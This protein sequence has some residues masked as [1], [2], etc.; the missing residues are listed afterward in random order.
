ML[1]LTRKR[2]S[3]CFVG[4]TS[5][6]KYLAL[7]LFLITPLFSF[8]QAQCQV[9]FTWDGSGYGNE[10]VMTRTQTSANT[11]L[12][13]CSG[14]VLV[15][16]QLLN[17]DN[18]F[19]SNVDG[20]DASGTAGT[21]QPGY[22]HWLDNNNILY[23]S[24]PMVA[25]EDASLKFTF[26]KP[27][28]LV[29]FV[30]SDIDWRNQAISARWRDKVIVTA[31]DMHGN[32]VPLT[33]EHVSP[34]SS[35]IGISGQTALAAYSPGDD[36]GLD[37]TD[38]ESQVRW[39][40][41]SP[42]TTLIMKHQTGVGE[43]GQEVV[44][45][46]NFTVEACETAE[47][48]EDEYTSDCGTA[49]LVV[50]RISRDLMNVNSLT[51]VFSDPSSI[52]YIIFDAV[53]KGGNQPTY[54][55]L[56]DQNGNCFILN[57]E[58]LV[59]GTTTCVPGSASGNHR[60]Q[61]EF[62]ANTSQLSLS[63]PSGKSLEGGTF[64]VIRTDNSVL[65]ASTISF[66]AGAYLVNRCIVETLDIPVV[67]G[68]RD[69]I[70]HVPLYEISNDGR[71]VIV[72]ATVGGQTASE[73]V[74]P[75]SSYD[76]TVYVV[77]LVL[78]DADGSDGTI[79]IEVESPSSNGQSVLFG[80]VSFDAECPIQPVSAELCFATSD[81]NDILYTVD[82]ATGNGGAIG[83]LGALDIESLAYGAD[84]ADLYATNAGVFG[85][86][87]KQT[88][89]FTAIATVGSG[90][91]S[92]GVLSMTDIDG[93]AYHPS[94]GNMIASQR[95]S[96]QLDLIF[97]INPNTGLLVPNSFGSNVDY[98]V[99]SGTNV[100]LDIDDIAIDP[101]TN[102]YYVSNN[103]GGSNGKLST[104]D[105]ST[106][107][108]VIVGT[109]SVSDME[110][111]TATDDGTLIGTSGDALYS[112]NKTNG[113]AT[114]LLQFSAGSDFEGIDCRTVNIGNN[115][116]V[117]V[118]D[119]YT[120]DVDVAV[121]GDLSP[122]DSDPDGDDLI[123][124]TTPVSDPT[125][126]FVA[127]NPDGSFVYVPDAGYVGN[128]QFTYEVCDPAGLCDQAV[129]TITI[130]SNPCPEES[131]SG[132]A[133]AYDTNGTGVQNPQNSLGAA[134]GDFSI[135]WGSHVLELD[136]T[137]VLLPGTEIQLLVEYDGSSGNYG[138]FN[139]ESSLDGS[140][141][142][143][144]ETYGSSTDGSTNR[145][146][147][148]L[149]YTVPANGA[150][151]IKLTR[152]S[153]K[154]CLDAVSYTYCNDIPLAVN[155]VTT[156]TESTTVNVL[157]HG[158][159]DFG[160]DGP[161]T[162]NSYVTITMQASNGSAAI[163]FNGA[164]TADDQ[165]R[166]TPDD[167]FTGLDSVVYEIC[168][169][170]GDC[171]SATV[172]ITVEPD[173]AGS[174]SFDSDRNKPCGNGYYYT[175]QFLGTENSANDCITVSDPSSVYLIVAEVYIQEATCS[176]PLPDCIQI[177]ADG[178]EVSVSKIDV[179]Q[180]PA[181]TTLEGIYRVE[182]I[183]SYDEICIAEE[184]TCSASSMALYI[185]RIGDENSTGA[186]QTVN[187]EL[188]ESGATDDC[189]SRTF[190]IEES[191][192]DRDVTISI[193]LHETSTVAAGQL[194]NITITAENGANTVVY[195]NTD[196]AATSD[197]S[198]GYLYELTASIPGDAISLEVEICS[199]L[200]T[201]ESVGIGMISIHSLNGC[202][203]LPV[204]MDDAS[205]TDED[206]PVTIDVTD[207]DDFGDDGPSTGTITVPTDGDSG[208]PTDGDIALDDNGTPDDPTDDQIIYTPDMDFNGTDEFTYEICDADG[209]CDEATV[210]V[211]IESVDDVPV[212]V[213]DAST[214]DEDT[215]VAIDVTD[216]DDFGGDGP[217]TGTITVP[218]DG[219]AGY[220]TDGDIALDDNG[221]PDDP[222][223][224]EIIYT[225]D[226]DFNGTDEF[227]Y[228]IC[229]ADGDCDEATVTVT[230]ESVDD[231]PVA[232]DDASTTDED[233]PVAIDV[234]DNE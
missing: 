51:T 203:Y 153:A 129:A 121:N 220:P 178:D 158:N 69:V 77:E 226:M 106:G 118:D 184:Y 194:T 173:C 180:N 102:T 103:D 136:L 110:G 201:G 209:D 140:S 42:V 71:E 222:T 53:S 64:W 39:T 7:S 126:G 168:D 60:F 198:G 98:L 81:G 2:R 61:A 96:G 108:L 20:I 58:D 37:A 63:V 92:L 74:A 88:G 161:A 207:N 137:D 54:V 185:K 84:T 24:D 165:L 87:N 124:D 10:A 109:L 12:S 6:F 68:V 206:T 89:A 225:P 188:I 157:L 215:P 232:V 200:T 26:E 70:V 233:T 142:S 191:A 115:P 57:Q 94:S 148:L 132:N 16:M 210:T 46:E 150:R 91:G 156:T 72:T 174:Q 208:Y 224:D 21:F 100:G 83:A 193:P 167:G 67:T 113:T 33:A 135:F 79:E 17:P 99:I 52:Q 123:Y 15:T 192:S 45:I 117:A 19:Y 36:G 112:I 163:F 216:N 11:T 49:G 181:S 78:N 111:L 18:V 197:L 107:E 125:N 159:D 90:N 76:S 62:P 14:P 154:I 75:G 143:D 145:L 104:L 227:T 4:G 228:E 9:D 177:S 152:N 97:Y 3:T 128:D 13:T 221:T 229:D 144:M 82:P 38:P 186:L 30:V 114:F 199:P 230:I 105:P 32:N 196:N 176:G 5:C 73:T 202:D 189:V 27:V 147:Q 25:G 138:S 1:I 47:P 35:T 169:L 217:S 162:G 164:G 170:N 43:A 133:D 80:A 95:R 141:Y 218:M 59:N 175:T 41:A 223:D 50:E 23:D 213:D 171:S 116:P 212:A 205:T 234:T 28:K 120:T 8:I 40:S 160:D 34:E 211:T 231:V 93:L 219:D 134:N 119:N 172:Y 127:I 190:T 66:S 149:T 146:W 179:I 183:G 166:Y 182:F 31:T 187:R 139:V 131:V 214:T 122:N 151:W 85:Q 22:S 101:T 48:P 204:A 65:S 155:D 130:E 86:I 56:E 55:T 195:T 29:D 44:K